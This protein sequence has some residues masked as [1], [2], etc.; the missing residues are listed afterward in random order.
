[1]E[2][3]KKFYIGSAKAVKNNGFVLELN[4]TQLSE[5]LKD[6]GVQGRI[7]EWESTKT[8][9]NRTLKVLIAEMK[10]ENQSKYRTHSAKVINWDSDNTF[11][12][13]EASKESNKDD[14]LF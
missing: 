1:M 6:P 4:L 7:N 5:A 13:G 2:I 8:G 12:P 3:I 11:Q 9:T 10:E 14:M